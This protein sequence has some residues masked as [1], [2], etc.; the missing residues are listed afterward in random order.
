MQLLKDS[1]RKILS[2]YKKRKCD[3]DVLDYVLTICR[4]YMSQWPPSEDK[5]AKIFETIDEY[6]FDGLLTTTLVYLDMNIEFTTSLSRKH[7]A[8]QTT[9]GFGDS[10]ITFGL[11]GKLFETLFTSNNN[12]YIVGGKQCRD[13]NTCFLEIFAHEI[14][15]VFI[16]LYRSVY[17]IKKWEERSHGRMFSLLCRQVFRQIETKHGLIPGFSSFADLAVIRDIAR[18]CEKNDID[19]EY[20][21]NGE[22]LTVKVYN[23]RRVYASVSGDA[24]KFDVPISFLRPI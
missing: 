11:N 4:G 15:H 16:Y 22:W 19:M 24:G 21:D 1:F 10:V 3:N 8:G 7:I 17:G 20:F 9:F 12:Q 6:L 13:I 23:V 2:F 5:M 14:C 18:E